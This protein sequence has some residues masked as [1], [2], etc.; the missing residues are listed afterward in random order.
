[1]IQTGGPVLAIAAVILVAT[2]GSVNTWCCTL[3][4]TARTITKLVRCGPVHGLI[5]VS[6]LCASSR[7][8][9]PAGVR[10]QISRSL[11]TS[12]EAQ[13]NM[14]HD[15]P[16]FSTICQ[17]LSQHQ[18]APMAPS[19]QRLK[20]SDEKA[21]AVLVAIFEVGKRLALTTSSS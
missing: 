1:M 8:Q 2:S 15:P 13:T 17:N 10:L 16:S 9:K 12:P 18:P 11:S 21:A 4:G 14:T 7:R 20:L 19:L 6:S 5:I 3:R